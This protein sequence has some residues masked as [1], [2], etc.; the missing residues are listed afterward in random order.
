[1]AE[2]GKVAPDKCPVSALSD[3]Y[4]LS[5]EQ[6]EAVMR[7]ARAESPTVY[8]EDIDFWAVTKYEDIK[9]VLGDKDRF[10][11]EIT[12]QPLRPIAPEVVEVFKARSF[13]PR[14]TLSNNENENHARVRRVAQAAF[15]PRRNKKLEPYI[16]Q[17]V[18]DAVDGFEA[19][20][21]ADLVA[22]LVYELPALVL[23][24][25]LGIPEEDVHQIKMWADSRLVLSF[26][27]P[28]V[29]EQITA[30]NHMADYWDYCLDLV[31][32]RIASPQDDLPSD[33]LEMRSGDDS[34]LEIEDINNVVFGLLL[35]GHETTTNMSANAILTLLQHRESWEAIVADPG[36]I[37]NAVEECLRFRP[38]VVAWRRLTREDVEL[39][40]V[41]IPAGQ[42]ILCFLPSGNR[43][44]GRV[45]HGEE[46]DISRSDARAHISFGFGRHF[47][48]GAPL[49][50]FELAVILEELAKRLPGIRLA[51][52]QDLMPVE[53]VQF[54]GPKE[55]WV[56]WD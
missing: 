19:D 32:Q 37:P 12:L 27:K 7:K 9:T 17:L 24:K 5:N 34:I 30:A 11:A 15:S 21:R 55:L 20:K 13:S 46:F 43:D 41:S 38:S 22:Q 36:L 39:S 44:E 3:T 29:E 10:S 50:R 47:C 53:T 56:E 18:N 51:N 35:A 14:P 54:R 49:A 6:L 40:G 52:D 42:R 28:G 48:L 8:L 45:D 4:H 2:F 25:L 26:G 33:M 1:M 23:F 16:R 31:Q